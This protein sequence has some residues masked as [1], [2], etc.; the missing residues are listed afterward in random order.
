MRPIHSKEK[1]IELEKEVIKM[2]Q[3]GDNYKKI[4][5]TLHLGPIF[6]KNCLIKNGI[7]VRTRFDYSPIV[8]KEREIADFYL[9]GASYSDICQ[10]YEISSP[11]VQRILES[12]KIDPRMKNR[13]KIR[14]RVD[15]AGRVEMYFN[16]NRS[17]SYISEKCD[18]SRDAIKQFLMIK[19][20]T[21]TQISRGIN[22]VY[23]DDT[24][25]INMKS[26]LEVEFA[27]YLS[28]YH[29]EWKYEPITID[30]PN[31]KYTP[32]FVIYDKNGK[33]KYVIDVKKFSARFGGRKE[34]KS[35]KA[36]NIALEIKRRISCFKEKFGSDFVITGPTNLKLVVE[37]IYFNLQREG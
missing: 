19:G 30:E 8:G 10:K 20:Y 26:P 5:K 29:L 14:K 25:E 33:S 12:Y 36:E 11:V 18:C 27:K 7:Q 21:D 23:K 2:Y 4:E 28:E 22:N 9:S 1:L 16:L 15:L 31:F 13:S 3:A 17:L 37:G 34:K 35:N 6:V 24:R 32:D